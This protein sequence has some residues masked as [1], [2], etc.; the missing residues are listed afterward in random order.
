MRLGKVCV[1]VSL[2]IGLFF[3][4]PGL[5]NQVVLLDTT[6]VIGELGWKTYPVNGNPAE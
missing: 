6:S 3:T 1:L 5:S 2:S 4:S